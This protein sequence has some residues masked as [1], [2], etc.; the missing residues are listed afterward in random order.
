MS[1][2]ASQNNQHNFNKEFAEIFSTLKLDKLENYYIANY[3]KRNS[4]KI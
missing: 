4:S 1:I 2:Y 3:Y